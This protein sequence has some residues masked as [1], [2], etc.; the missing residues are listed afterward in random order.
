MHKLPYVERQD[1]ALML[2]DCS[3]PSIRIRLKLQVP[4]DL[5]GVLDRSKQAKP[6]ASPARLVASKLQE[7]I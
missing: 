3:F 1:S 6:L 7:G 5:L 4:L 2:V